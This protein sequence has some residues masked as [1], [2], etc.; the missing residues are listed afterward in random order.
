MSDAG[1]KDLSFAEA[2]EEMTPDS[3][4]STQDQIKETLTDTTDR[5]ARGAQPDDQKS[6]TQQAFD[7]SQRSNDHHAH[8]G[9]PQSIG[10]KIKNTV[11]LGDH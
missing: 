4:K 3:T 10:D 11:G 6:S 9:A 2:K 8:G 5:F 1:R 7:K